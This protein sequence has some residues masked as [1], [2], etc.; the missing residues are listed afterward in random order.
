MKLALAII[1]FAASIAVFFADEWV[2]L[3]KRIVA[4][5]GVRLIV[6]L[7]CFSW[8]IETYQAWGHWLLIRMQATLYSFESILVGLFPFKIGTIHLIR[9]F[10]LTS[11][12]CLPV[13]L[14]WMLALY[15]KELPA[16]KRSY[17]IGIVLW[18]LGV[19]LIIETSTA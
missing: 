1:V 17:Y 16:L 2:R 7:L 8:L 3:F 9:I 12:A 13:I 18:I 14:A 11:L 15:R 6:P 5:P 10:Y 4:I 19:F